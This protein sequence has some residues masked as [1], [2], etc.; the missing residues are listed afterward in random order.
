MPELPE[1]ETVRSDL[2]RLVAGRRVTRVSVTGRRTI[3]RQSP[4]EFR[5]ALSGR[6][7]VTV[8]RRGKYLLVKLDDGAVLVIHLRMSGQLLVVAPGSLAEAAPH[9]HVVLGLDDDSELHFVDPRT[10]GE[11]FVTSELAA[12][13]RPVALGALGVDP[14]VDGLD[15][16]LVQRLLGSRRT[17]LKALL[18]DQHVLAGVGNIYAD[19]ICFRAGIRPTR[20][21]ET[22]TGEEAARLSGAILAVLEEAVALRGS[23]LRDA[24]YRDVS[25]AHGSFQHRHAVYGRQGAPCA[26]CGATV[27]R[28][29]VAGRSAHFCPSCQS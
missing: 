14:L 18:L 21:T 15:A 11:L 17:T 8:G 2:E 12:D 4:D 19:E 16:E 25:G 22:V 27:L 20:R 29:R 13:G 3:R 26:S 1:V 28:E 9:T 5:A 7:L 23:T 6:R 10:F 24:R